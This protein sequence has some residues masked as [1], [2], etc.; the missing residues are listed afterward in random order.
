MRRRLLGPLDNP[1][2]RK[3]LVFIALG[4]LVTPAAASIVFLTAA[5]SSRVNAPGLITT[6]IV[7]YILQLSVA[8]AYAHVTLP[9]LREERRR[10]RKAR[11]RES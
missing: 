7:I 3:R 10:T 5:D 9:I 2:W 1:W 8:L 11:R 6:F 4:C